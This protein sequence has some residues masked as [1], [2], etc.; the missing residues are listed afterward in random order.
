MVFYT[1]QTGNIAGPYLQKNY[2][3][4]RE[5]IYALLTFSCR[6]VDEK[7]EE[8]NVSEKEF[9]YPVCVLLNQKF[10][11][12]DSD[13][14][15]NIT[16][17]ELSELLRYRFRYLNIIVELVTPD[18]QRQSIPK[19]LQKR[20]ENIKIYTQS[21][22]LRIKNWICHE[23][24]D[25]IDSMYG[26]LQNPTRGTSD[27]NIEKFIKFLDNVNYQDLLVIPHSNEYYL[28]KLSTWDFNAYE[29]S[30]DELLQIAY[31]IL[32]N[33][34]YTNCLSDNN[35]F[36]FLFFIRDNY[37]IGNPFHN[38]RHA[39]DV[40]QATNLFLKR[41]VHKYNIKPI[42]E[43]GLLLAS[44]GH[45][46]GHPGI[47]NAF[48]NNQALPLAA[49][50]ENISVLEQFHYFQFEQIR[51]PY[52][53]FFNEKDN[54]SIDKLIH[55]SILATD[56]AR[57][58]SF[59]DKI[60]NIQNQNQNQHQNQ[61]QNQNEDDNFPLLASLLIKCAD[62][63]NVCRPLSSSCKWGMSLGEEFRQIACLENSLSKCHVYAT[64]WGKC[65]CGALS[66][67]ECTSISPL[68]ADTVLGDLGN[69]IKGKLIKDIEIDESVQLVPGLR[70][71]QMFFIN[72]FAGSFFEK[73]GDYIPELKFLSEQVEKN[74]I[75][76]ENKD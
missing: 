32:S 1:L 34:S 23:T 15:E 66:A 40:L 7:V 49:Y 68:D 45:D 16:M 2:S 59:I 19:D 71:S 56:M 22:L 76:W 21:R 27:K 25:Y 13:I 41:L 37:R 11:S 48:F 8:D 33:S 65:S 61:N 75:Y 47:T 55:S 28:K 3:T 69:K 58:D 52:F 12:K 43:Y 9:N 24:P 5:L 46:I 73:I 60:D 57:H 31:I 38:F 54:N 30:L 67:S 17:R 35:L 42:D 20:I 18:L 14:M 39:V 63:S 44:L 29:F 10:Q 64:T 70:G 74:V 62:I 36:S 50:F 4:I 26:Y 51:K 72:R 6:I 53:S